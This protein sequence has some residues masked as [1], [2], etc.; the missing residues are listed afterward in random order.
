MI[1]YKIYVV[2]VLFP[3][4]IGNLVRVGDGPAAVIGDECRRR[5][6][7]D[8]TMA[9]MYT[10]VSLKSHCPAQAGWEGAVCRMIRESED[11]PGPK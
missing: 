6:I 5:I 3:S 8:Q 10:N 11:L 4:L 1:N 9:W 7:G 2:Q